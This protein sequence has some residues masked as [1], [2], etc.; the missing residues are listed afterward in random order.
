VPSERVK[1]MLSQAAHAARSGQHAVAESMCER[2]TD[3]DPACAQA[4][5][6]L[7]GLRAARA[8][9]EGGLEACERAVQLAPER[10]EFGLQ[11]GR[12][13]LALGRA[14]D[15]A[16]ALERARKEGVESPMLA[17]ALGEALLLIGMEDQGRERISEFIDLVRDRPGPH[18]RSA[19]ELRSLGLFELADQLELAE[20]DRTAPTR[21]ER[22]RRVSGLH[23]AARRHDLADRVLIEAL[24]ADPGNT[25]LGGLRAS[26]LERFGRPDDAR[27]VAAQVLE[28]DADQPMANLAL[29]RADRA[30]GDADAARARLERLIQRLAPDTPDLVALWNELGL[31]LDALG[32]HA[33]A[34][35]AITKAQSMWQRTGS[36]RA[37]SPDIYPRRLE[38]LGSAEWGSLASRWDTS[39]RTARAAPVFFV[40]FPRSGTTLIERMLGSHRGAVAIEERPFVTV[41]LSRAKRMLGVGSGAS[42]DEAQVVDRLETEHLASLEACYW[43]LVDDELGPDAARGAMVVDKMPLNIVDLPLIRRVFPDARVLVGLRDPRDCCLSCFMQHFYANAALIHT[44]SLESTAR[45]YTGVMGLWL[46]YR[47]QLGLAWHQTRYEDLVSDPQSEAERVLGFL[48]L[49]WDPAVLSSHATASGTA[50][51]TPSYQAVARPINARAVARWKHYADHLALVEPTLAPFIHKFGY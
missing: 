35:D 21:A 50:V 39:H 8:D 41:L 2:A 31:S 29:A 7:A 48:G 44:A 3:D 45:L 11:R 42:P 28:R 37:I 20:I 33:R 43:R 51:H 10:G 18:A 34:F 40:G 17:R 25:K 19:A 15:A 26:S 13:L 24:D 9:I 16:E 38:A 36:V 47:E 46:R 6:M 12:L 5:A 23:H 4:W 14:R 49:E 1:Q 30:S 27:V 22:A 32:E